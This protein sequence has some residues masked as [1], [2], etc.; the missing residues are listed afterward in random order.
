MCQGCSDTEPAAEQRHEPDERRDGSGSHVVRG[1][2]PAFDDVGELMAGMWRRRAS[3]VGAGLVAWACSSPTTESPMVVTLTVHP[4]SVFFI[5]SSSPCH[6]VYP[7]GAFLS[8]DTTVRVVGRRGGYFT[9]ATTIRDESDGSVIQGGGKSTASRLEAGASTSFGGQAIIG[10]CVPED[11]TRHRFSI[12]QAVEFTD[13]GGHVTTVV[14]GP[15]VT[16]PAQ[17]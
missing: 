17:P 15:V 14:N 1:L 8:W 5:S 3:I 6:L 2:C 13:D 7:D 12:T 11:Y 10:T 16:G 4:A 9:V